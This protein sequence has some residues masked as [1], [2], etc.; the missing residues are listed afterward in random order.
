MDM[1]SNVEHLRSMSSSAQTLPSKHHQFEPADCNAP[2][3]R[4]T[5][6]LLLGFPTSILPH[7]ASYASTNEANYRS[8]QTLCSVPVA[9][10]EQK[11]RAG[12]RFRLY[13][14]PRTR[15]DILNALGRRGL[16]HNAPQPSHARTQGP[17]TT[18]A[19]LAQAKRRDPDLMRQIARE[20]GLD[21]S[22]TGSPARVVFPGRPAGGGRQAR[23]PVTLAAVI[24]RKFGDAVE[25]LVRTDGL[26]GGCNGFITENQRKHDVPASRNGA[27]GEVMSGA[28]SQ[29]AGGVL[30][31]D[32][33]SDLS[34]WDHAERDVDALVNQFVCL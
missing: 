31:L 16:G 19:P 24:E 18:T 17:L 11:L 26:R 1:K 5:S 12:K 14:C 32:Q 33:Q 25:Y 15:E 20:A 29:Q 34:S 27:G 7:A 30:T 2:P 4:Q 23:R 8:K 28:G 6:E 3:Y 10:Y 9:Q 21:L 22:A 13:L